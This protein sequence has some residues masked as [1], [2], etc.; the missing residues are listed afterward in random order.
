MARRLA[1]VDDALHDGERLP[2]LVDPILQLL[3]PRYLPDH[4]RHE[5]RIVA[6]RAEED[7]RDALELLRGRLG[8][9]LDGSEPCDNSPQFSRKIVRRTSSFD[10]K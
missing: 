4:H 1:L 3:A 9:C 2:H 5:R 8:G 10:A 7:L 6:P